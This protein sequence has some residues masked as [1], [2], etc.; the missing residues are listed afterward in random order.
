MAAVVEA[1]DCRITPLR[2]AIAIKFFH[3]IHLD[4]NGFREVP[5]GGVRN[6]MD[7]SG[8]W[9]GWWGVEEMELR[10]DDNL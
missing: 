8:Y 5:A 9:S 2:V 10:S 1:R 6:M 4:A 3:A 7:K